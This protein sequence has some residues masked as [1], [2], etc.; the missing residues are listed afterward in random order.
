MPRWQI[1]ADQQILGLD[2]YFNDPAFDLIQ[3]PASAITSAQLRHTDVLIVRSVLP[4]NATLLANSNVRF[5]ATATSGSDHLD[6]AWLANQHISWYAAV[7]CNANAVAE[8]VLCSIA[9]LR[10]QQLL[11]GNGLTAVVVG[12]GQVGQR[13]ATHLQMLGFTV[14]LHDPPRA[15]IE[16]DFISTSWAD[17]IQAD[18]ICLHT[19]LTSANNPYPT[20]H[21]IDQTFLTKLKPGCVLLN[22]GRGAVVDTQALLTSG[23]HIHLCLDVYEHEPAIDLAVMQQATLCTPHIAGHAITAKWRASHMV[24]QAIMNWLGQPMQMT[25]PT[26]PQPAVT[27]DPQLFSCW[28]DFVLACYDPRQDMQ[29]MRTSIEHA[30]DVGQAFTQLR[31]Q[32][33]P[34]F[35][36]ESRWHQVNKQKF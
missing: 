17:L 22:A 6:K 8:Y 33:P 19:P 21:L 14:L 18:L 16:P 7:G 11:V 23:N 4:V 24:Y 34:R 31:N 26:Y 3:L 36:F 32:Y 29:R 15:K 9:A 1:V 10:Q 2:C 35:E 30:G 27:V 12:V 20:Y 5:V 13:V 25:T 28:E